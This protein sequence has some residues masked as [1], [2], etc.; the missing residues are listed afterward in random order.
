MEKVDVGIAAF[1]FSVMYIIS[2][3]Y[4]L[5]SYVTGMNTYSM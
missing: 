2:L 1:R 3:K 5:E 4:T